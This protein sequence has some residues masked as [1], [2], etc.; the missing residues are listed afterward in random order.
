MGYL[1]SSINKYLGASVVVLCVAFL[2]LCNLDTSD[3]RILH[4][5]FEYGHL[6]LFGVI[7]LGILSVINRKNIARAR[8]FILAWFITISLGIVTEIIQLITPERFFEVRD[9]I[10]D[11]VGAGCFLMLAYPFSDKVIRVGHILR[12]SALILILS[13][14]IPIFLAAGDQRDMSNSFPLIG[15]FESSL[16]MSRWG[17]K[18]GRISRSTLYAT[19]GIYSLRADLLPSEYPG[20]SINY[21]I[22]DWIGYNR[23]IFDVFLDGDKTLNI[24]A[25]I[26]DKVHNQEYEDRFNKR[27]VL[28]PGEN[29]VVIDLDDVAVA[30][31]GREMDMA[32]IVNLCIFSYNLDEVRTFYLDNVRLE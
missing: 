28:D 10:F 11:A 31:K 4:E 5:I 18:D 9:I 6:P 1:K 17:A 16:E 20:I 2:F 8:P 25:R 7:S 30:P 22:R 13:G 23:L 27:F 12:T 32:D 29:T 26:H 24:T 19:Q 14:T 15:T 21:L 3:S